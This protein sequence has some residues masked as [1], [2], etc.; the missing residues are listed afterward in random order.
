MVQDM[1]RSKSSTMDARLA[2]LVTGILTL[3]LYLASLAP[4]V[5]GGDAG[6]LVAGTAC[7][8]VLHPPGYPLYALLGRMFL[9]F[10]WRD[11]ALGMNVFSAIC[12]TAAVVMLQRATARWSG[13]PWAGVLA[14][15]CFAFSPV[16]WEHAV[17]AEVFALHHVFLAALLWLA[18]AYGETGETRWVWL[19]AGVAA[20]GMSH[21]HTLVFFAVPLAVWP[22]VRQPTYWLDA[23]RMVVLAGIGALGLLPYAWLPAASAS[24]APVSWGDWTTIE[25]AWRHF[26][27]A[28]YG[29][30]QLVAGEMARTG[31]WGS[32]LAAW[33]VFQGNAVRW[34]GLVLAGIGLWNFMRSGTGR[35]LAIASL[36]VLVF[37]ILVF[38]RLANLSPADPLMLSV[39]ARFWT[40]PHLLVCAWLGLG[41]A[42]V[43][44]RSRSLAVCGALVCTGMIAALSWN[45]AER[46]NAR[47]FSDYG[48]AW[49]EKLP[50][51][52][53]L[54][55]R[56]DLIVNTI[57]YR[58]VCTGLR[59]DIRLLDLERM[60]YAWHTKS[61]HR[62]QP[63]LK[64]PGER[65]HPTAAGCYD[66]A[67]L[68]AANPSLGPW[69][70]AGDLAPVETAELLGWGLRPHGMGWRLIPPGEVLDFGE[71][72][73]ESEACLPDF[74]PP[75]ERRIFAD[76]W[77]AVVAN[78]QLEAANRRGVFVLEIAAANQ[79]PPDILRK[80]VG[81]F[82]GLAAKPGVRASVHKN[83]G[84]AW[85]RLDGRDPNAKAN[86]RE[87]WRRFLELD[88]GK[89]KDAEVI[90]Q[91]LHAP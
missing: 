32:R 75:S 78:D 40:S 88:G 15:A 34:V 81:I 30:H 48:A 86:A 67:S 44:R 61:L 10:P 19:G 51:G 65:Y 54:L 28:D 83:L 31:G 87:A 70:V 80:A 68:I 33:A 17:A 9:W 4:S 5:T 66:L 26:T 52:A 39:L 27:R 82:A 60:T 25:G 77:A 1:P 24:A 22:L 56:G 47:E 64:L 36:A 7:G 18:V 79:N 76:P 38:N 91:W 63:D 12:G 23:K 11:A 29:T 21:H 73:T 53:V 20:F 85:Q 46:R 43:S 89:D 57:G 58:Q 41:W 8:G 71:W 42:V 6:E 13:S 90:R 72:W 74:P 35:T 84:L 2:T 55:A 16:V 69:F 62:S 37:Y 45:K 49:I 50:P 14:A 59:K 3:G